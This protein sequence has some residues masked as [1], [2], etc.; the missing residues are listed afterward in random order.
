MNTGF[1]NLR[2]VLPKKNG[3][4]FVTKKQ[5]K[6]LTRII[7]SSVLM[8]GLWIFCSVIEIPLFLEATLFLIPYFVIGYDI[9]KK[10]VK[11]ILNRNQ[12]EEIM[13]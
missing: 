9:L 7:I 5:K 3:G 11:G 8:I 12:V 1:G 2:K 13:V 6:V 10:A 4:I